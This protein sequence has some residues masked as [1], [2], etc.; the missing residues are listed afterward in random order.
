MKTTFTKEYILANCGCYSKEQ[1]EKYLTKTEFTISEILDFDLPLRDKGWFIR[2]ECELTDVE[3]RRFAIGCALVVLPIYESKYPE[4]KAPREAIQAAKDYLAGI[5]GIGELI[6]K[7]KAA[8]AA[9]YATAAA[10]TASTAAYAADAAAYAAATAA[11]AADAAD[12]AIPYKDLL[13]SFF[14]EF[15]NEL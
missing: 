15:T 7:R 3:L 12:D 2:L 8:Y 1:A 9:A 14:K 13:L 5:I 10:Y 4:N 11:T 6:V